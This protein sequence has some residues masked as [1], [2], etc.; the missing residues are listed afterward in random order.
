MKN[1]HHTVIEKNRM[2]YL[3][4]NIGGH[5]YILVTLP[6]LIQYL[7]P[8]EF[9]FYTILVQIVTITQTAC[10]V[11][12]SNA[13]L[14]FYIEYE[15]NQRQQLLGTIIWSFC[16]LLLVISA[17]LYASR[18]IWLKAVFP[19][20]TLPLDPYML[21][22]VIWMILVS[23]R[24]L[25]QTLVKTLE[26]STLIVYQVLI[27][28]VVF[29]PILY[30]KVV[31]EKGGLLG[32]LQSLVVAESLSLIMLVLPIKS[33][34]AISWEFRYLKMIIVYSA[35]LVI[36][37]VLFIIFSNLDRIIL[38]RYVS[39]A[40]MGVYGVGFIIGNIAAL[41]V[42]ANNS[43]Y[44]PRM[45]KIMKNEG[46]DA[47]KSITTHY[48]KET[49]ALMGLVLGCLALF[50]DFFV[51]V[52]GGKITTANANVVVV[53]I[54]AGHLVRSQFLFYRHGFFCKNRTGIILFLNIVLLGVG[55]G[56]ANLLAWLG[57]MQTVAYMSLVSH[58]IVLP[59][60]YFMIKPYISFSI[61]RS[62]VQI[63]AIFVMLVV[64]IEYLL[65]NVT[66][67]IYSAEFWL[68]KLSLL[69]I[70][71]VFYGKYFISF[72]RNLRKT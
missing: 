56:V 30:W 46:D 47:A 24:G 23:I 43:S 25:G 70:T 7:D 1:K 16:A 8:E 68:L 64:F 52:L 21:Y 27:Y 53:G 67:S 17:I 71:V 32:V 3:I 34:I 40:D 18:H 20:V 65:H 31:V 5:L 22:V 9:G 29:I 48:M 49:L 50:N 69:T 38:S 39:L 60:A 61:S 41:I 55:F 19:N 4:A 42:T 15:G 37:S 72:I 63:S 2:F 14:K 58:L 10:L 12:F 13:I 36:S 11:I 6:L 62:V 28:G 54:A 57:G 45:L 59:L 33:Y 51:Y 66:R 44:S 35:P 26:K